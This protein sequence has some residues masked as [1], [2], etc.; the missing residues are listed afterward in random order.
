MFKFNA[1]QKDSKKVIEHLNASA[2]A[3]AMTCPDDA[4]NHNVS[5]YTS[6]VCPASRPYKKMGGN[7]NN[8]FV[9]RKDATS[10][11]SKGN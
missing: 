2:P 11:F 1:V 10:S 6:C 4:N 9:C 3:P 8:Q 5:T 7:N